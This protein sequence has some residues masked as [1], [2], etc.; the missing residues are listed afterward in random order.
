MLMNTRRITRVATLL[1]LCSTPLLHAAAAT[2]SR[3]T[4]LGREGCKLIQEGM[5]PGEGP[6]DYIEW[7]CAGVGGYAVKIVHADERGYLTLI[8]PKGKSH[9]LP[10]MHVVG[11]G[12]SAIGEK[13]EWRLMG[14]PPAPRA[15][16]FR[17]NVHQTE[18]EQWISS[19]LVTKLTVDKVCVVA[20]IPP[21]PQQNEQ[22]RAAADTA[23]PKPCLGGS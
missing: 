20:V 23:A 17:M 4:P 13:A 9:E 14:S 19:L 12:F 5:K 21:G 11:G 1:L 16:I 6:P 3:Y 8:D 15:L 18:S 2:E 7:R 22:A 10:L